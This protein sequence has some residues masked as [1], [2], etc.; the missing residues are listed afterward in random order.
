MDA[1][2]LDILKQLQEYAQMYFDAI[3]EAN[4]ECGKC[5]FANGKY[6]AKDVT[7]WI[8]ALPCD[9]IFNSG[10]RNVQ[11]QISIPAYF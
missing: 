4:S 10:V 7:K 9:D 1:I 3:V 6:T 2:N 11:V 8:Y 5:K